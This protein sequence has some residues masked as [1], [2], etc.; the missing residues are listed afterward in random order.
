V[1]ETAERSRRMSSLT[2]L[3][4]STRYGGAKPFSA[5]NTSVVILNS[6]RRRTGS[7]CSSRDMF[8]STCAS[9][10]P[11]SGILDGLSNA[12]C[13]SQGSVA[14]RFGCD[15]IFNGHLIANLLQ[16]I[17]VKEFRKSVIFDKNLGAYFLLA[18]SV[19]L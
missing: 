18:H 12:D 16:S 3:Q 7:Q 17:S 11:R 5:L 19:Y 1:K 6:T 13:I 4:S 8:T 15:G 9:D 14:T 2:K 10:Q